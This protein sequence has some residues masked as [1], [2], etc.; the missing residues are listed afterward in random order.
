MLNKNLTLLIKSQGKHYHR[1]LK[2]LY[3]KYSMFKYL[4]FFKA[5]NFWRKLR[6]KGWAV[7]KV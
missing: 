2:M 7:L 1:N 6:R 3:S 5:K 4:D